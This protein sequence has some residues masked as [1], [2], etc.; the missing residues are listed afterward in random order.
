[1]IEI[2]KLNIVMYLYSKFIINN[3]EKNTP[4]KWL[5]YLVGV[6]CTLSLSKSL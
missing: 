3:N 1:M 2:L 5:S 6:E 4:G